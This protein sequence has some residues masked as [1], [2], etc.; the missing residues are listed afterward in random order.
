M[1]PTKSKVFIS[2]VD[3]VCPNLRQVFIY[4]TMP[5]TL[6]DMQYVMCIIAPKLSKIT[7]IG[8]GGVCHSRIDVSGKKVEDPTKSVGKSE[9]NEEKEKKVEE[10][11]EEEKVEEEKEVKVEEE[12]EVKKEEKKE[13]KHTTQGTPTLSVKNN[14]IEIK[15]WM[16]C[17]K[18]S[19][20]L[21][22]TRSGS[23]DTFNDLSDCD[24]SVKVEF[25]NRLYT[26]PT[27]MQTHLS[28]LKNHA[29]TVSVEVLCDW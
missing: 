14:G 10:K 5:I 6:S 23:Y 18:N 20:V 27:A 29:L 16:K 12:K 22:L 3:S 13:A 4:H 17:D 8:D 11:K 28:T 25:G 2:L 9:P 1:P 26:M 19:C 7:L 24:T 21:D 15:M